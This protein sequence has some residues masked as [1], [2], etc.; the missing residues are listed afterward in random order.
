VGVSKMKKIK[1]SNL[2]KGLA[3]SFVIVVMF[4]V[5]QEMLPAYANM[6]SSQVTVIASV[7]NVRENADSSSK[8]IGLVYRGDTLDV[9]QTKNDWDQIKLPSNQTGWINNAYI[10]SNKNI[11]GTVKAPVLNVREQPSLSSP[12]VSTLKMGVNI[13]VSEEQA[14]WA[15]IVSSS[16]AHGWVST[17]Y[18]SKSTQQSVPS[19]TNQSAQS[20]EKN[21]SSEETGPSVNFGSKAKKTS[22]QSLKGKTIVLDPGHGGV[23]IGTTSIT[24]THEKDLNLATAQA[25]EQKLKNAGVNVIMTRDNDTF[26]SLQQRSILSNRLHADAFISFHY[27]WSN[28]P[29]VSGLTDFYY[30]QSKDSSLAAEVLNGVVNTTGLKNIGTK[31]DDLYVL[32]NNSQPSVLIELGFLSN[33]EDDSAAENADYNDKVAQGVYLGLLDYFSK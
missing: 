8:I 1:N 26:I 15:K 25:V 10:T 23:D 33:K 9:I 3:I 22:V 2:I 27:N 20:A 18:I 12:I 19:P 4:L 7:L 28:D 21:K 24:G 31:F 13:T 17:Y 11:A 32:R 5:F 6:S 14:G 16:G 30:N 29:A